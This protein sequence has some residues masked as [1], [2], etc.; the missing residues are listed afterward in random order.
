[1]S[2]RVTMQNSL[3]CP[4]KCGRYGARPLREHLK[5]HHPVYL[6]NDRVE[7]HPDVKLSTEEIIKKHQP[8][9]EEFA[10]LKADERR[11]NRE[12]D[13]CMMKRRNKIVTVAGPSTSTRMCAL[14]GKKPAFE[15][16]LRCKGCT[17]KDRKQKKLA[18]RIRH[19]Q[20]LKADGRGTCGNPVPVD[21][22][23]TKD[24]P[25]VI[26]DN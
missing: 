12:F 7:E 25:L 8:T 15:M 1:M 24:D 21:G 26:D 6:D 13:E 23:G 22:L 3:Q 4:F 19:G 16:H 18:A 20:Q 14:C 17:K 9:E 11:K 10:I 2:H 5:R